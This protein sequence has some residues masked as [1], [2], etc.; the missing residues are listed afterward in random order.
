MS[1]SQI[2]KQCSVEKGRQS[3]EKLPGGGLRGICYRCRRGEPPIES[4]PKFLRPLAAK[5]YLITAAQ[6]ATPVHA[7][8]LETLK[9]AA[10]YLDAELVVVPL[11][12]KN[13]TSIWSKDQERDDWW[14]ADVV[15]Y[16]FNG[17]KKL[18]PH[19]VL[20][21]DVKSQP[22]AS[23]PLTG[24][25]SLTGAESCIIAH[26]RMQF[27]SVPVP[28]GRYPKILTTTG[29]CTAR[30]YSDTRAGKIGEFHHYLGALLVE[31]DGG[32]FFHLRQINADRRDGSFIDVDKYYTA[33]GVL[34]APPALGL[35]MGDMHARFCDPTV[36]RARFG[37]GGVVDTLDPETLVW[38]D[39]HDGYA[40]NPHHRGNPFIAQAKYRGR[41]GDVR[42]EVAYTIDFVRSR[43]KGRQS[44]IV[45]SNHDDFLS[46]WVQAHDWKSDPL[47]A[48]FYLETARAMLASVKLGPGGAEYADP[49][50]YWVERLKGD[51]AI[52]CLE[53]D[54]SFVLG[55]A[56]SG[57]HGDKG[58]NGARGSLKNL[59]RIGTR[60]NSGH[61]HSPGI[62]AGHYQAG[63]STPLRLE[64]THGPGSWL[65]TDIATY[66]NGARSLITY[67]DGRWRR[68]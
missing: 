58:P 59:S 5:R 19:L 13:P 40:V 41:V 3:F 35:V 23:S 57:H 24:F 49:F 37:P 53:R 1:E 62:E 55:R 64:Y 4:A 22:T 14:D 16:L 50:R 31:L 26:P 29:A 36:D 51:A 6:N 61:T 54:E 18:H 65:N 12:Y 15:P 21:A 42:E 10:E 17:R 44:V 27:R 56:E 39:V 68:T 33:G 60:M 48:E 45:P 30:N 66:A 34:D 52:R 32:K 2:C 20:A 8:F 46:R 11:R 9:V 28:S 67:I 25:E 47:N 7:L 43:T 38:H 63:T